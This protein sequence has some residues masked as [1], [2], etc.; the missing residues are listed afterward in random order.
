VLDILVDSAA[1]PAGLTGTSLA[2]AAL[3][4]FVVAYVL[5]VFEDR[6]H[7]RK[8]KPVIAAAGLMWIF[9]ALAFS[10][11]DPNAGELMHGRIAHHVADFA[12][13]FLFLMV[14]M[15]YISAIAKHNVFHALNAWMVSRGFGLRSVFWATGLMAFFL[16]PI[17]DNL[18]TALLMGAVV[19][20]VGRGNALFIGAACTNIVIAANAGGAFSPFGDITTLMVWQEGKVSTAEFL[21]LFVPCLANWMVPAVLM[22]LA[23][24]KRK[25]E[26]VTER[27]DL[28][29][30]WWIVVLMF[31]ATVA[32]AISFHAV[33][34]L[35]PF[36]GMT[37]G[38]CFYMAYGYV[39]KMRAHR[40]ETG[41]PLDVFQDV[42]AVEWDTLLFFFGVIMCVGA[43]NELGYLAVLSTTC[44]ADMGPTWTNIGVG[45]L[46]AVVDNVPVMFAV[47]KMDPSMGASAAESHFQ[48][49]LVTLTAGVGGSLLSVG[50][51]AG[52]ALMGSARGHYT[53]M[54]HLR[55]AP[56][57]LAGYCASILLHF[58]L[59][60]PAAGAVDPLHLPEVPHAVHH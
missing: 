39:Q 16:S 37:T 50:S 6:I 9:T 18:T 60:A 35:P 31:L 55:W 5:V 1:N 42:A 29:A 48:W 45:V 4:V 17:A 12:E 41:R 32:T 54:G 14:A 24:P 10:Q 30:G 46:S 33:L 58:W 25:P 49:L 51:A 34:H 44:Y 8:S 53:F 38:L 43:L 11:A 47:L 19:V 52:V 40:R 20:A 21:H 57:I 36:L 27:V 15:T 26:P 28:V 7:L 23:I 2:W 3:A 59:N 22:S 13:L 56:A